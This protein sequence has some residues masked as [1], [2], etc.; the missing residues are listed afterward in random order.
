MQPTLPALTR[1]RLI[2]KDL[3]F[4]LKDRVEHARRLG[5]LCDEI[6]KSGAY[7]V[8]DFI[9][10]TAETRAAFGEAFIVWVD[11]IKTGRFDDTNRIFEPPTRYDIRVTTEGT[12][13]Y[14]AEQVAS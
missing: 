12:P 7:V 9:C 3:G 6:V 14:W 5:W 13:E 8:A 2:H 1:S 11:R 4:E 10:P